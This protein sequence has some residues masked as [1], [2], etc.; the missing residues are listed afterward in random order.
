[1][2]A[3]YEHRNSWQARKAERQAC[4]RSIWAQ[5]KAEW[6]ATLHQRR[7]ELRVAWSEWRAART[8]VHRLRY[9]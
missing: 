3:L 1:V 4:R 8:A 2:A 6:Q 7:S 5:R 9:A